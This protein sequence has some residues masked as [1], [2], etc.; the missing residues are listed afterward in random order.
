MCCLQTWMPFTSVKVSSNRFRS[1]QDKTREYARRPNAIWG[2]DLKKMGAR[3]VPLPRKWLVWL[4]QQ[5][6]VSGWTA[7]TA[8]ELLHLHLYKENK[9]HELYD[10]A[11]EAR[12]D[13]G[14]FHLMHVG[15]TDPIHSIFDIRL[16]FISVDTWHLR[17][18]DT[19]PQ[20]IPRC[21][22]TRNLITWRKFWCVVCYECN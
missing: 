20:K 21:Y 3:L 16:G 6:S 13:F 22:M 5:T 11:C 12:L 4:A 15:E 7:G 9:V 8:V 18:R 14:T 2:K 17:I 1:I 19:G 10:A